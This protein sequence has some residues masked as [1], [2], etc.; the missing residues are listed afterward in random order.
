MNSNCQRK[1]QSGFTLIELMIVLLIASVLSV[2]GGPML[3][4][5]VKKNRLRAEAD[6]M[7]STLNLTR[8]EAV[9]RNLPVSICQS[10]DGASCVGD[11]EDGWIVFTNSDGDNTVDAGVDQVIRVFEGV[12]T[13]YNLN[14]TVSANTLTY[15]ADGS[16][17]GGA[18]VINVCAPD[19]NASQGWSL[20]LNTVGR[21][22][23]MK[24][25]SSCS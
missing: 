12:N 25:A 24:G 6:R 4:E 16:Y 21:A 11:W 20:I 22:R 3:A 8:S 7:L 23:A 9:K 17:A 15:F 2:M 5:T 1:F 19:A 10:S 14:A 18:G 13:G